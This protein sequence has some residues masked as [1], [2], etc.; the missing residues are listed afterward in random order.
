MRTYPTISNIRINNNNGYVSIPGLTTYSLSFNA[1]NFNSYNYVESAFLYIAVHSYSG[2]PVSKL[3]VKLYNKNEKCR[4]YFENNNI[5]SILKI[6]ITAL[7]RF[8]VHSAEQNLLISNYDSQSINVSCESS[9]LVINYSTPFDLLNKTKYFETEIS[10]SFKYKQDFLTFF[11]YYNKPI[12]ENG[13]FFNVS[14]VYDSYAPNDSFL[15]FFPNGWKINLF[16][17][18]IFSDTTVLIDENN[19]RRTFKRINS[20]EEMYVDESG[21]GLILKYLPSSEQYKLFSPISSAYKLYDYQGRIDEIHLE[22]GKVIS[23]DYNY[24]WMRI[25]DFA[26]NVVIIDK[27]NDSLFEITSTISLQKYSLVVNPNNN[28]LSSIS[29]YAEDNTVLTDTIQYDDY[30]IYKIITFDQFEFTQ[31][32]YEDIQNIKIIKNNTTKMHIDFIRHYACV[33]VHDYIKKTDFDYFFDNK[34]NYLSVMEKQGGDNARPN[35]FQYVTNVFSHYVD[36]TVIDSA[37]QLEVYLTS[38]NHSFKIEKEI[39][40]PSQNLQQLF[41]ITTSDL[42]IDASGTYLFVFKFH[43]EVEYASNSDSYDGSVIIYKPL[44]EYPYFLE[45]NIIKIMKSIDSEFVM[46][47]IEIDDSNRPNLIFA[48]KNN[49]GTFVISNILAIKLSTFARNLY[50]KGENSG[51]PFYF[52]NEQYMEFSEIVVPSIGYMTEND[53]TINEIIKGRYGYPKFVFANNL[54]SLLYHPTFIS[55]FEI[56]INYYG[57]FNFVSAVFLHRSITNNIDTV[58]TISSNNNDYQINNYRF[59]NNVEYSSYIKK[60]FHNNVLK[61]LD[62]SGVL[63]INE[64]DN[65]F[66][67]VKQTTKG[68]DLKEINECFTYDQYGRLICSSKYVGSFTT[69]NSVQYLSTLNLINNS[70]DTYNKQ[71]NF[72]YSNY[73]L[74]RNSFQKNVGGF[75]RHISTSCNASKLLA[76]LSDGGNIYTYS[77]NAFNELNGLSYN[78]NNPSIT[79]SYSYSQFGDLSIATSIGSSYSFI[80]KYN[81]YGKIVEYLQTT[82]NSGFDVVFNY[83]SQYSEGRLTQIVDDSGYQSTTTNITY[84]GKNRVA[85]ITNI[86]AGIASVN[87]TYDSYGRIITKNSTMFGTSFPLFQSQVNVST[88]Y[89]YNNSTNDVAAC[90]LIIT[91]TNIFNHNIKTVSQSKTVDSLQRITS[92]LTTHNNASIGFSNIEYFS[93][94]NNETSWQIKKTTNTLDGDSFYTY[95]KYGSIASISPSTL[96]NDPLQKTFSYDDNNQL[97]H[98]SFGDLSETEIS[99]VYDIYGNILSAT[100]T[101]RDNSLSKSNPIIT[102]VDTYSYSSTKPNLLIAFNSN[103]ITYDELDNPLT[104]DGATLTYYRGHKLKTYS[105]GTINVTYDYN[106][107]GLRTHKLVGTKRHRFIYENGNLIRESIESTISP[108]AEEGFL[109]LYGLNGLIGFRYGNN[110]YIYVKNILNDVTAIYKAT[111]SSL[112]LVARYSYDAY[113]NTTV[114]NAS[115]IVNNSS[116]FIGNINPIRYRSYYYD[117][118]T[119][120]YYCKSRYYVPKL[121][122]WLTPDNPSYLD[123]NDLNGLNSYVYCNNNPIKYADVD[124][125]F[126][127]SIGLFLGLVG[128]SFAIGFT[129]SVVSQ[130]ITY[131]WDNINGFA[132]LQASIDG[133]FAAGSMALAYTGIGFVASAVVGGIIGLAQYSIDSAF[134]KDFSWSGALVATGLGILGGCISGRGMQHY[135]SIGNNLDDVGKSATKAI[136]TAFDR[137]GYGSGYIATVNLWNSRLAT[138]LVKSYTQTFVSTFL[139]N[140]AYIPINYTIFDF[141]SW[142]FERLGWEW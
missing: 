27:I 127:I 125:T 112:T 124:G 46:F 15:N 8:G 55:N 69:V 1:P 100:K 135:L 96:L 80:K 105:K 95:N 60:D 128:A 44:D 30:G 137:Y 40:T 134:H 78:S 37:Q 140:A 21:S 39:T 12:F 88:M 47:T 126:A 72:Q 34:Q 98:E 7:L 42:G 62:Y 104:L 73:L 63:V 83:D 99:Y 87:Y 48:L 66:N 54:T 24:A 32:F 5:T 67:M 94:A 130:G 139:R 16:E 68:T 28:T 120:F 52:H 115:G 75:S 79:F 14:L 85:S 117:S 50:F 4:S 123:D 59:I 9:Y 121:R 17:Q 61:K 58:T 31:D 136:L 141:S 90:A 64:F 89:S 41:Y 113:G 122:R 118:E 43:Q 102:V 23:F 81:K 45:Q 107:A 74:Y 116:T 36:E 6:D 29:F 19:N 109:Y 22:N 132:F 51:S 91:N 20:N 133:L 92:L 57:S 38:A 77:Y 103:P 86:E 111:S 70:I 33:E 138:S 106:Y 65:N 56:I 3:C 131:G 110:I 26:G 119:G 97:I 93:F 35:A 2:D 76:G 49:V 114:L 13:L 53:L 108:Y 25:T 142:A 84:N 10:S 101:Y 129:A 18:I 71:T 82:P 11:P